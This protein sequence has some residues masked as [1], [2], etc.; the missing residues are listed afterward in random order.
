MSAKNE[1]LSTME[2]G[3]LARLAQKLTNENKELQN[4]LKLLKY[5]S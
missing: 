1:D 2:K 5:V 4:S 3:K